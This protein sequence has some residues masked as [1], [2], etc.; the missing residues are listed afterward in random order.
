MK[1][2]TEKLKQLIKE[3]LNRIFLEEGVLN[4]MWE[5]KLDLVLNGQPLR[6]YPANPG[7]L[8][9]MQEDYKDSNDIVKAESEPSMYAGFYLVLKDSKLEKQIDA[10]TK[11]RPVDDPTRFIVYI[12]GKSHYD[13]L[14]SNLEI[15]DID[16]ADDIKDRI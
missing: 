15:Q 9:D 4:S 11:E 13:D 5:K 14:K 7:E 16:R 6:V 10:K 3:E 12:Q 1:L 8:E 2:T